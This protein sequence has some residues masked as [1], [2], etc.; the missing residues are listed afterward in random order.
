MGVQV[1]PSTPLRARVTTKSPTVPENPPAPFG[2]RK[3]LPG[4]ARAQH[5]TVPARRKD[6]S[7]H[8]PLTAFALGRVA[9]A[10]EERTVDDMPATMFLSRPLRSRG[11]V[12]RHA[13]RSACRCHDDL[14]G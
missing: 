14:T 2:C 5:I 1:P 12:A 10:V 3:V 13:E 4:P 8:G 7:Q 6:P 11:V 9:D